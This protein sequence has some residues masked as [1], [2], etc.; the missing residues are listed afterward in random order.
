MDLL[1]LRLSPGDDLRVRLDAEL[2]TRGLRA[3]FVVAGVGS[4]RQ[5]NLR[6][7]GAAEL[8]ALDGDLEILT[9]SGSLS[10][11]GPHLHASVADA[12]GH[13]TGGH[14]GAGCIVRTTAEVLVAFLDGWTFT[15][16]HDSATG[17]RELSIERRRA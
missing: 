15:R 11:D 13:V 8:T 7:A 12:R 6:L 3:G 9:L 14:V 5:A 4:L 10:L 2:Q 16:P 17:Y 1:P